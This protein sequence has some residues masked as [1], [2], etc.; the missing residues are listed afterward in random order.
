MH[1]NL[2]IFIVFAGLYRNKVINFNQSYINAHNLKLYHFYSFFKKILYNNGQTIF[3]RV[4][5]E[6]SI[7]LFEI[8]LYIQFYAY[9]D[10]GFTKQLHIILHIT[11]YTRCLQAVYS[12]IINHANCLYFNN[13]HRLWWYG[14]GDQNKSNLTFLS[15]GTSASFQSVWCTRNLANIW[16]REDRIVPA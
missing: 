12:A 10:K 8:Q 3:R 5:C 14:K 7:L 11:L 4:F 13:K 15:D 9:T 6:F 16:K 2:L 1:I